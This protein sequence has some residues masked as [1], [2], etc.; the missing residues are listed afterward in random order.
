MSAQRDPHQTALL[1]AATRLGVT[2]QDHLPAWGM[3]VVQYSAHGRRT[4]VVSGRIVPSLSWQADALIA[5]KVATKDLLATA[6]LPTVRG[7]T[8]TDDDS[9][10]GALLALGSGVVKPVDGTNAQGV[11]IGLQTLAEVRSHALTLTGPVLVETF[12]PGEDLRLHIIGGRIVAACRRD[13]AHI[14]GD[15][16]QSIDLINK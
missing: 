5:N 1:A 6:G 10:I 16:R 12:V 2:T 15:G 14:I 3:D 7:C 9:P 13:P 11:A 8:L 4:R